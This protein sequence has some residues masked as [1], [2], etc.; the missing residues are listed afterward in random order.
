M[1][2]KNDARKDEME[3]VAKRLRSERPEASPLELDRIKMAAMSR[4]KAATGAGRAGVRRLAVAGMTVG[5]M[6]AGTGGVI[7]GGEV[8]HGNGNAATAQY[9]NNCDTNNNNFNNFDNENGSE[10]NNGNNNFNCNN[11]SF[12]GSGNS[13]TVTTITNNITNST[14]TVS[15]TP[16]PATSGVLGSTA[17]KAATSKRHITLHIHVP[18][19]AKLSRVTIKVNGKTVSV[20]KGKKASANINLTNLPCSKGATT[21]LIIAITDNGKTVRESHQFH[22]CQV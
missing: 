20:L 8:G 17:T 10:N 21:V 1:W 12:N 13:T 22:L 16:P 4:A 3:G 19:K 5:L 7:A 14:V 2:R 11:N 15:A 9:G 6:A 18:R